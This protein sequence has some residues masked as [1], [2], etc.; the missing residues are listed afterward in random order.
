MV[1]PT[2]VVLD[3]AVLTAGVYDEIGPKATRLKAA[4][5]IQLT[6][7]VECASGE[8][9]QDGEIEKRPLRHRLVSDNI[10]IRQFLHVRPVFFELGL[11][12]RCRQQRNRP[13][14]RRGKSG[15]EIWAGTDGKTS[16]GKRDANRRHGRP[17]RR[18]S[19][20]RGVIAEQVRPFP[21]VLGADHLAGFRVAQCVR[22]VAKKAPRS[23]LCCVKGLSHHGFHR[24][25][26]ETCQRA[27]AGRHADPPAAVRNW[28]SGTIAPVKATAGTGAIAV[29]SST[30]RMPSISKMLRLRIETSTTPA[31]I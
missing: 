20:V 2:P 21:W 22:P 27:Q 16:V 1:L 14:Q 26:V 23:D 18:W 5:R 31:T 12:R 17:G 6:Q 9:V 15:R 28:P 25:A 8:H 24:I 30:L 19:G 4:P 11:R 7:A 10:T 13:T 29:S 3:K